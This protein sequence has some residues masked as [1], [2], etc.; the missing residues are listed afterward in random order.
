MRFPRAYE[1]CVENAKA[2]RD[3]GRFYG[4]A[5]GLPLGSGL[6]ISDCVLAFANESEKRYQTGTG[7]ALI[8]TH[9][10]DID[11]ANARHF[12]DLFLA[13]PIISL[14]D[15]CDEFETEHGPESWAAFLPALVKD[16]VVR[17]MWIP[18][19]PDS[20]KCPELQGGGVIYLNQL[21]H[22]RVEWVTDIEKQAICTLSSFG[23]RYFDAKIG[24]LWNR[25]KAVPLPLFRS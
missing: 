19:V 25:E 23:L 17:A 14:D 18:P 10:C 22:S 9:E 15:F 24:N 13:F 8:L 6:L 16:D 11:Q 7:P 1:L 4:P 3:F 2:K 5:T 20:S 21:S 12:N